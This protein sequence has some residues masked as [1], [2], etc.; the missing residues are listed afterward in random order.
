[1][2]ETVRIIMQNLETARI[3]FLTSFLVKKGCRWFTIGSEK[4]GSRLTPQAPSSSPAYV[5]E[6]SP[7]SEDGRKGGEGGVWKGN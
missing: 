6:L 1:M 4:S 3:I 2:R 5:G 7:E